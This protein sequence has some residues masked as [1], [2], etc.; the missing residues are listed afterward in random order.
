[1]ANEKR[2]IRNPVVTLNAAD[3]SKWV[4]KL[5][6][7][8]TRVRIEDPSYEDLGDATE[9]GTSKH[10]AQ[11]TFFRS[12]NFT[13]FEAAMVTAFNGDGNDTFVFKHTSGAVTDDEPS[14]TFAV[15]IDDLGML[16]GEKNTT[17][18]IDVTWIVQGQ[19]TITKAGAV[20]ILV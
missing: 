7:K 9:K 4:R 3:I 6:L 16:F 5:T 19:V 17:P 14:Y 11:V 20:T 18:T 13:E 15:K 12:K 10:E 1:M 2:V 8:L